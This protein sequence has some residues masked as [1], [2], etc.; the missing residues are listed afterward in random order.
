MIDGLQVAIADFVA[1]SD[2]GGQGA[3]VEVLALFVDAK[4]GYH[5]QAVH[6]TDGV[7][8]TGLRQA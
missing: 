1:R 3:E 6:P 5:E 2:F 4:Q 8:I 7:L